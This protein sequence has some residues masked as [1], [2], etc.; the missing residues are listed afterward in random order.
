M[1]Y[2]DQFENLAVFKEGSTILPCD[3]SQTH[4]VDSSNSVVYTRQGRRNYQED[5]TL[6]R[7]D[8]RI[9]F[10]GKTEAEEVRVGMVGVFDGHN[11]AEASEMA[12]KYIL[13]YF[14]LHVWEFLRQEEFGEFI[15]NS[16]VNGTEN[17]KEFKSSSPV[18][19]E[20]L[21]HMKILKESLSMAI[22][23]IDK[24]F[25]EKARIHNIPAGS[26]AVVVLIVDNQL[27]V[28]NVGDSRAIVCSE[29]LKTP[30]DIKAAREKFY[31]QRR[32]QGDSAKKF[33]TGP[34]HFSVTELTRD[35]H[36]DRDDER[37]RI[38]SFGGF[39]EDSRVNGELALSRSIGDV[40]YKEYGVISTP[41]VTEWQLGANDTYL[42]VASDG[43]FEQMTT[44]D[45][46][47]VLWDA[48]DTC[49]GSSSLAE[50]VVN[51]AFAS[52]SRDNLSAIVVPLK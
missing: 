46:A 25:S 32:S 16:L 6:C 40:T 8:L 24:I 4:L 2:S 28:A 36:P 13:H 38:E 51:S 44:K 9:P 29:T 27:L 42:V 7:L 41:E 31:R 23:D 45:V 47:D 43:I 19:L 50:C 3:L 37:L 49:K 5:R 48:H 22:Q 1:S 12:S 18:T 35:H 26:T 52:G 33:K 17:H 20:R 34:N 14:L 15:Y 39:V 10:P 21:I 30:G 11:G